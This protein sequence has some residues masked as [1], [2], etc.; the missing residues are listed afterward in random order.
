MDLN[1]REMSVWF[2]FS[3]VFLRFPAHSTTSHEGFE[4]GLFDTGI[5]TD[6]DNC[7]F[8]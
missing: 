3:R 7:L 8:V 4:V 5:E 2:D 1:P 6:I